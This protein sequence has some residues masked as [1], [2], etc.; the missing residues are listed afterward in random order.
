MFARFR[1][2]LFS[3]IV[4][5]PRRMSTLAQSMGEF[6]EEVFVCTRHMYR[7]QRR[8][9]RGSWVGGS[10]VG[11]GG[12]GW[13][14]GVGGRGSEVGSGQACA[15]HRRKQRR[16][17]HVVV[18]PLQVLHDSVGPI[19][20]H[21]ENLG[22]LL[23]REKPHIEVRDLLLDVPLLVRGQLDPSYGPHRAGR[24][25]SDATGRLSRDATRPHER[26]S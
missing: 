18:V 12:R 4:S 5:N 20:V 26:P 8:K 9:G 7:S 24:L 16:A 17:A 13:G 25:R 15:R 23:D 6:K 3:S 21:S 22:Q 1:F 10:G 2:F 14:W 19:G 11:V